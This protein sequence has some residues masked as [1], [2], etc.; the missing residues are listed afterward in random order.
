MAGIDR[1]AFIASLG[2]LLGTTALVRPPVIEISI[3]SEVSGCLVADIITGE[4]TAR[5]AQFPVIDFRA[6]CGHLIEYNGFEIIDHGT[7]KWL[8]PPL[9]P[10]LPDGG[11]DI[12]AIRSETPNPVDN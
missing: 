11:I 2:A 4:L 9:L 10:R 7:E 6:V 8:M 1:R 3:V 12:L 5:M